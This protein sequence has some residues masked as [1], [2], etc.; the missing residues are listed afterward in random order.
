MPQTA[1]K[2]RRNGDTVHSI[3][4]SVPSDARSSGL[5][6][7]AAVFPSTSSSSSA[8]RWGVKGGFRTRVKRISWRT[9]VFDAGRDWRLSSVQGFGR[10]SGLMS[11][12]M[13]VV[14]FR[15]NC[16]VE[17]CGE[18]MWWY[19]CSWFILILFLFLFFCAGSYEPA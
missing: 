2:H 9:V 8:C 3:G 6:T 7:A 19:T 16:G 17:P 1:L 4:Q 15:E 11:G 18:F 14:V 13:C 5:K 12:L 10:L